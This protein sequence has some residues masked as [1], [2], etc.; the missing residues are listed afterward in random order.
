METKEIKIAY[1]NIHYVF[2]NFGIQY[3]SQG[4][5]ELTYGQRARIDIAFRYK[6]LYS[7]F[8]F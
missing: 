6:K 3:T 5:K 1:E 4:L 7:K 8:V 2:T